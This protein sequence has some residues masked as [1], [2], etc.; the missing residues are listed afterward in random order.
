MIFTDS[1]NLA[2]IRIDAEVLRHPTVIHYFK[3][4]SNGEVDSLEEAD[5]WSPQGKLNRS[6]TPENLV[7]DSTEPMS[8][9]VTGVNENYDRVIEVVALDGTN[10][11]T[12]VSLFRGVLTAQIDPLSPAV[13]TVDISGVGA[14]SGFLQFVI[15][16]SNGQTEMAHFIVPNGYTAAMYNVVLTASPDDNAV[17][18]VQV[19]N[20]LNAYITKAT[21]EV[22]SSPTV[23]DFKEFPPTF[24]EKTFIRFRAIA[25]TNNTRVTAAYQIA[26]IRNEELENVR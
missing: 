21:F 17:V 24:P 9:I 14:T 16:A 10:T 20:E 3:F 7:I 18:R 11:S 8:I 25:T 13:N 19:A 15:P 26:L 23:F 5:I 4:G 22:S 12:T 6:P 2:G 1:L